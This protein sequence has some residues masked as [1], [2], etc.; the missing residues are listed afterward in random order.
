M[1]NQRKS[2]ENKNLFL[3]SLSGCRV[4]P[5]SNTSESCPHPLS[6]KAKRWGSCLF[7]TSLR[8]STRLR[9]AIQRQMGTFAIRSGKLLYKKKERAADTL[10]MSVA[11]FTTG[12]RPSIKVS[13]HGVEAGLSCVMVAMA[14]SM[15]AATIPAAGSRWKDNFC[16]TYK[17][18]FTMKKV[19]L[20]CASWA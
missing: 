13:V 5:T 7:R 8:A 11:T 17:N 6:R 10:R 1:A 20:I 12:N 3:S 16:I 18:V 4:Q 14:H 9:L 19:M 15:D 2:D